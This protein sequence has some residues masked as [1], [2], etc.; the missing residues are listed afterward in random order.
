MSRIFLVSYCDNE[1]IDLLKQM[2]SECDV[3]VGVDQGAEILL[4]NGLSPDYVIGDFDSFQIDKSVLS[5]SCQIITLHPEKDESDLEYAIW[6]VECSIINTSVEAPE[7]IIFNNLQGRID[8]VLTTVF[9]LETHQNVRIVNATQ[10]VCLV[11][12]H[13]SMKLP[14][15]TC[16]SLIPVSD[17]VNGVSTEGLYF[18]LVNETLH[19]N[20]SRGLSNKVVDKNV[21]V[22]FSDG[23]LLVVVNYE[24]R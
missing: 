11:D 22:N 19:R 4:R 17:E 6:L 12:K 5:E 14:P 8:H 13:F 9:L 18:K 1:D 15:N 7:I 20:S 16:I 2:Y 21:A 3:V 23:K 10:E 24:V